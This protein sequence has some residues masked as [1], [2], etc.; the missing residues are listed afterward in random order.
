MFCGWRTIKRSTSVNFKLT[1]KRRI[2]SGDRV[3]VTNAE[4]GAS[5][6]PSCRAGFVPASKHRKPPADVRVLQRAATVGSLMADAHSQSDMWR[7]ATTY[8]ERILKGANAGDLPVEQPT[9]LGMDIKLRTA[10]ALRI[11]IPQSLLLRADKVIKY[12]KHSTTEALG[13]LT[14]ARCI[15][16]MTVHC[17]HSLRCGKNDTRRQDRCVSTCEFC[18]IIEAS[19]YAYSIDSGNQP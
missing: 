14:S 18:Q 12:K 5:R 10:K 17:C 6:E 15:L 11:T 9:K 2:A 8:V 7:K 1:H 13:W 4:V 16:A 3:G 19:R